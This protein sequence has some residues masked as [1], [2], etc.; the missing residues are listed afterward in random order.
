[1][2]NL[3]AIGFPVGWLYASAP[4][5]GTLVVVFGLEQALFGRAPAAAP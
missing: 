2:S 1:M 4:V 5:C 3:S